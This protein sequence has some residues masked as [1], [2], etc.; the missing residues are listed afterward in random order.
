MMAQRQHVQVGA[1]WL[2]YVQGKWSREEEKEEENEE[3]VK[4]L[5][6]G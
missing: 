3:D 1:L 5:F 6:I 4:F 2:C